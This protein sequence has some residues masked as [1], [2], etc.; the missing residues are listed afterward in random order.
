MN[1]PAKQSIMVGIFAVGLLVYSAAGQSFEYALFRLPVLSEQEP[2]TW[3]RAINNKGEVAGASYVSAH[4]GHAVRWDREFNIYD[5]GT[6]DGNYSEAKDTNNLGDFVGESNWLPYQSPFDSHAFFWSD[7]TMIDLG[8]FGGEESEA[9]AIN[10]LGQVTGIAWNSEEDIQPFIW[11]NGEM[12]ALP[13]LDGIY[14]H[15]Y[16]INNVSQI[17]GSSA[18]GYLGVAALWE[19]GTVTALPSLDGGACVALAINDLGEIVGQSDFSW[20]N[21]AHACVWVDGEIFDL[22]KYNLSGPGSSA[23]GINNVGQAVGW[24]G[25]G[26]FNSNGF[27]WDRENGMRLLND[28]IPPNTMD[29]LRIDMSFD[30]NDSGQIAANGLPFGDIWNDTV[31]L[32]L[33][34]VYPTFD[35]SLV[36]PGVGGE[37]NTI[38]A[39]NLEPGT[40]VYFTW[41]RHGGG[42]KIPG[43]DIQTNALQIE[44]PKSAGYAIADENG[45]AILE[46]FVAPY[47]SGLWVLVQAVVPGE[48]AV[49]N[50]VVQKFE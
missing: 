5:L 2:H 9:N 35:L 26:A 17:V 43:C 49:S 4:S 12:Q 30:I 16:D 15:P 34:P 25:K 47:A 11:E 20:A 19:N 42:A 38:T 41:S 22:H 40:Q 33:S 6:I 24:I 18:I 14:G 8:T 31:P 46:A 3:T 50:L 23:W 32:L 1:H 37:V 7:G 44:N 36:T 45:D 27:V 39:S 10:D 28:L 21:H 29:R 48:C 13:G